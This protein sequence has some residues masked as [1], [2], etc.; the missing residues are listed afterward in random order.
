MVGK[1]RAAG[2]SSPPINVCKRGYFWL[3]VAG[4]WWLEA[5]AQRRLVNCSLKSIGGK[6]AEREEGELES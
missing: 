3:G 6:G 4:G 2:D 1:P 5:A